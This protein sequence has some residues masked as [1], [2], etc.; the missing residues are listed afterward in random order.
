[1]RRHSQVVGF[2]HQQ[3]FHR[4]NNLMS[5][6]EAEKDSVGPKRASSLITNILSALELSSI[7]MAMLVDAKTCD[8]DYKTRPRMSQTFS[9]QEQHKKFLYFFML[10]VC[11]L[12]KPQTFASSVGH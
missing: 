1:M 11:L 2:I 10:F 12:L 7:S 8:N 5:F 3:E 9:H 4:I 6:F